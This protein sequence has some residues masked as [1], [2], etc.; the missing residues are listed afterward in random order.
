MKLFATAARRRRGVLALGLAAGLV[1]V[2]SGCSNS[3]AVSDKTSGVTINV[4]ESAEAPPKAMLDQF[5]KQTGIT[6]KWTNVDWDSLQTKITAA[7]TAKTYFADVT[8]VD[9]SR[10]GQ[11]AKLGWFYDM[12]DY[13]DVDKLK[14]DLPQ[15]NSFTADGKVVGLPGDAMFMVTTVNTK[16]FAEAGITKMPTT[17]DEYTQDLKTVKA[18]G[19]V[20][21]PLNI[22]FAAAEGLSTYWYE[23]TGAF[24][25]SVLTDKDEPAFTSPDSAGYKAAEWMIQAVKDGLVSPG[26][27]NTTDSQGQQNLMAT[28][29]VAS[30][31]SDYAGNVGTL[32]NVKDTSTV[33]GQVKYIPTPTSGGEPKNLDNPDGM[34]IPVTAKYPKAAAK[35]IEWYTSAAVQEKFA[36]LGSADQ[37]YS[38]F[39]LPAH[40][41]AVE[42]LANGDKLDQG[43]TLK[44]MFQNS[45]APIF[46][47]GAPTWYS[48]LSKAVYTNLHAAAAGSETAD[49]AIKKIA[50]T[51][52]QLASGS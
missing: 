42:A 4:V 36:G 25:G 3:A 34:G 46:P 16:M 8:D 48:S 40:L 27:I 44:Q 52:K 15:L 51:A 47:G 41:T 18:K 11:F 17:I 45:T 37:L 33:T 10:V 5:T 43:A 20:Q 12:S 22:P 21:Y 50:S 30:T 7:A 49:Q 35:F 6:V 13:V 28:G 31:F 23:T 26:E 1:A 2:A 24:G 9:W 19:V 39:S 38:T 29:K 32:Y 14:A